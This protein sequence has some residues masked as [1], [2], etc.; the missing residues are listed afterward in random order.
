MWST[1]SLDK[2]LHPIV[3]HHNVAFL[4]CI[5]RHLVLKP[6]TAALCNLHAQTFA[7]AFCLRCKQS[8][9]LSNS[10]LSY[11]NHRCVKYGCGFTKSKS[12]KRIGLRFSSQ[13]VR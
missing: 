1:L 12:C 4:F 8:S 6:R 7:R 2:K 5:E 3:L 13:F 10:A 11:I 9:E